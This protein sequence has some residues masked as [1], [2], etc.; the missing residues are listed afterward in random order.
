VTP[1]ELLRKAAS[2]NPG[3]A[4]RIP[5]PNFFRMEALRVALYRARATTKLTNLSISRST[6]HGF[7]LTVSNGPS[8]V[9]NVQI[10]DYTILENATSIAS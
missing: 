5:C 4:I 7:F 6:Q 9:R 3:S 10:T 8:P 1:A 2:L